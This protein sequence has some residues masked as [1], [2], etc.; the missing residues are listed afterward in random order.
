MAMSK[1]RDELFRQLER[2]ILD[3]LIKN[4]GEGLRAL[5]RSQLN[6]KAKKDL[7]RLS[8]HPRLKPFRPH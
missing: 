4:D 7:E 2:D 3:C 8:Q 6:K 1:E 5:Y